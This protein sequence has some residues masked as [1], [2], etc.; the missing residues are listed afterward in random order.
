MKTEEKL[1]RTLKELMANESLS[2]ITVK[3][4]SDMCNINRQTFYYHFRDLYDLLTWVFLN[5]KVKGLD[6]ATNWQ[7]VVNAYTNYILDNYDFIQ[8]VLSSA[9][10]E[11]F[12]EFIFEGIYSRLLRLLALKDVEY[13]L[14]IDERKFVCRFYTAAILYSLITWLE[15]NMREEKNVIFR[16]LQ[17]LIGNFSED[18]IFKFKNAK[19][20][21]L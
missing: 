15:G 4:L 21:G 11:L 19:N 14:S 2:S 9:G 8:N 13:V 16:R 6:E 10:K 7:D 3:R 17:I 12:K 5:E 1:G 18:I 20:G